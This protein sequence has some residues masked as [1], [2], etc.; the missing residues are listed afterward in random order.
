MTKHELQ[1]AYDMVFSYYIT[2]G[3]DADKEIFEKTKLPFYNF[4]RYFTRFKKQY[5]IVTQGLIHDVDDSF[6]YDKNVNYLE[7]HFQV[8]KQEMERMLKEET[9]K[10]I[11]KAKECFN[12]LCKSYKE[13]CDI[14][15]LKTA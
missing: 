12:E 11:E 10:D 13:I 2:I 15:E 7:E 3:V 4:S 8:L 9:P 6:V 5:E 14:L 1:Y